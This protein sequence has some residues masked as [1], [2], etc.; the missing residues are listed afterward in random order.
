ML[1]SE[2]ESTPRFNIAD[3]D[4]WQ[5]YKKQNNKVY[6]DLSEEIERLLGESRNLLKLGIQFPLYPVQ[7]LFLNR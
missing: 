7:T 1:A 2:D 6:S 3:D 5:K 4:G